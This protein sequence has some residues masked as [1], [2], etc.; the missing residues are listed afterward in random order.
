MQMSCITFQTSFVSV[1][2]IAVAD[3]Y[4]LTISE[5]NIIYLQMEILKLHIKKYQ[6]LITKRNQNKNTHGLH[7][8]LA[9]DGCTLGCTAIT[10]ARI[11]KRHPCH[12]WT[13]PWMQEIKLIV[14]KIKVEMQSCIRPL[15]E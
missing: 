12:V 7:N 8:F 15:V 1:S 9:Q 2:I 10:T 3:R 6:P 13:L 11:P 14:S 5:D 4:F